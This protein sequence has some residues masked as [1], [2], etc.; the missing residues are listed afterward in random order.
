MVTIF[1]TAKPFTGK[2]K[3]SQMNALRS[4][5]VLNSDIEIILFGNG[6]GYKEAAEELGLLHIPDVQVSEK[7]TPL[8]SSM[9]ELAALHGRHDLQAYVNCDIILMEDFVE[10][11][12][13]VDFEHFMM[14]GQRWDIDVNEEID[15]TDVLWQKRLKEKILPENL[16]PPTGC[17]YFLYRRGIW[18]DLPPMVVGRAGYDNWLIYYCRSKGINVID[19][20]EVVIAIHQNHDYSHLMRGM[21]E[22]WTGSEAQSNI[23]LSGG[24]D[25]IFTIKDADWRLTPRGI[26]KNRCRGDWYRFLE[27]YLIFH[28]GSVWGSASLFSLRIA[29]VV[30]RKFNSF[31]RIRG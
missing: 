9:F 30:Y 15:F 17:D 1:T 12:K 18:K 21:D 27:V 20:T 3:I 10:A 24:Y 8:V 2:V 31:I 14:V 4:W 29:N 19:A 16:H 13:R 22:A 6:E 5:E 25:H 28:K 23:T 7:G 26:V 11:A